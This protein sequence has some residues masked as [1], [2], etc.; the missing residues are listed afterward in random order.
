MGVCLE[1]IVN[2]DPRPR[3]LVSTVCRD[4]LKET[5]SIERKY[6]LT[7]LVELEQGT[8]T[9]IVGRIQA[10][11]T[12][13]DHQWQ[14]GTPAKWALESLAI[15]RTQVF[16]LPASGEITGTYIESARAVIR[17][18][19]AQAGVRLPWMLNERLT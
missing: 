15:V 8:P 9:E 11:M 3:L 7:A 19:L 2:N 5:R 10:T 4:A 6:L 1:R 16:R 17:T 14:Q 18:R 13:E 12:R